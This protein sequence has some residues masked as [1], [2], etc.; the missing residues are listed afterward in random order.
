MAHLLYRSILIHHHPYTTEMVFLII[1]E[2]RILTI[3][4][5]AIAT[6]EEI[7]VKLTVFKYEVNDVVCR[8]RYG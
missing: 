4:E 1:M 5:G 6:I 8:I 3:V 7:L 2:R